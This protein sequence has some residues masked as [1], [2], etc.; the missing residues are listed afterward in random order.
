[1][2]AHSIRKTFSGAMKLSAAALLVAGLAAVSPQAGFAMGSDS[3]TTG[4]PSG[5]GSGSG[6]TTTT[7]D[8]KDSKSTKKGNKKDKKSDASEPAWWGDYQKAVFLAWVGKYGEARAILAGLEH[9][10]DAN[11]LNQIGYTSRQTGDLGRAERYYQAALKANP[12]HV[13]VHEYYGELKVI[14]GNIDGARA[15][16][17]RLKE[18]CGGTGCEEYVALKETI[19][20]AGHSVE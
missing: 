7:D 8:K 12:N 3:P 16:L 6:T 5:G 10:G 9:T 18:L 15:Y 2:T 13:G 19:E 20:K 4:K 17:A 14:Q 1:M 11:V